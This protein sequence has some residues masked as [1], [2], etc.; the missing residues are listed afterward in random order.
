MRWVL[1]A[2]IIFSLSLPAYAEESV[3]LEAQDAEAIA[4]A[5]LRGKQDAAELETIRALV[6][7]LHKV[8]DDLQAEVK[9][10]G[11]VRDNLRTQIT[12]YE[13]LDAI[14]V[15]ID[16]LQAR[17]LDA[18]LLRYESLI[19][20]YQAD[21]AAKEHLLKVLEVANKELDKRQ[22]SGF[23]QSIKEFLIGAAMFALG[24]FF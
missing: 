8:I 1:I 2:A 7:A 4:R 13:K 17:E 16:A 5:L 11:D 10:L 15:K 12:E 23:W 22:Q 14:R 19:K 20:G 6:P 3:T 18:A 24:K 9:T 21:I